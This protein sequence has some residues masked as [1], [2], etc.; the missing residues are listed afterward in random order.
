[1][2]SC[3]GWLKKKADLHNSWP[4]MVVMWPTRGNELSDEMWPIPDAAAYVCRS[5]TDPVRPEEHAW[6]PELNRRV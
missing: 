1:M 5:N 4:F 6:N 2:H 3:Q